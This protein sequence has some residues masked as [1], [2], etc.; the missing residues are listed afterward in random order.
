MSV[1]PGLATILFVG[2]SLIGPHLPGVTELALDAAGHPVRAEAQ[3]INGAPLIWNWDHSAEAQGVDGR[4][5]L[6]QGGIEALVLTE[7]IP[8][9][10]QIIWN[11]TDGLIARWGAA[12][13]AASPEARIYLLE[14][15]HDLDAGP[16]NPVQEAENPTLNWRERLDAD[17]PLW[18]TAAAQASAALGGDPVRIIPAGQAMAR[19][20]DAIAAG[21]VP[22]LTSISELFDDNIHLGPKGR[23][24]V[25]MVQ[26]AVL[27]GRSP[28][29]LPAKL[30]RSWPSRDAI[31]RDDTALAMQR[32]AWETVS[33]YTQ[34]PPAA[35][36]L[37]PPA[38]PTDEATATPDLPSPPPAAVLPEGLT[39]ITNANL[40]LNLAPVVDWSVQQPFLDVV[41]TGRTW[42]GHTPDQWGAW[43]HPELAE[44]GWLDDEGWPKAMPPGL[45]GLSLLILTDLPAGS[46]GVAGRYL[47]RYQGQGEIVIKGSGKLVSSE[48]GRI[49]FDFVPG[50]GLVDIQLVKID[51]ADPIRRISVVRTDR[52]EMLDRGE[53]FNPDFLARLRGVKILRFMGWM[54]TND[55]TVATVADLPRVSDYTWTRAGVPMP[56]MIALANELQADAW[57]CVP[58]LADD[59]LVRALATAARDGLDPGRRAWVELS[60]EVW[61]WLFSQARWADTQALARWGQEHKWVQFYALRATEVADIWAEVFGDKAKDRL[62]RV[63]SSHTGWVGLETDV[64]EAPLVMAEGRDAPARHF[65]AYGITGY[66]GGG[67]AGPENMANLRGWIAE[68]EQAARDAALAQGLTGAALETEVAAHR[69]DRA[70]DTAALDLREGEVSGNHESSLSMTLDTWAAHH[71]EVAR[72]HGLQLVMYEGGS[73]VVATGEDAADPVIADFLIT[74]SYSPQMGDLYR[75]L[76]EGWARLSDAPFMAFDDISAPNRYGSWGALRHLADDNP[77][78]DALANGCPAC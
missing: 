10:S 46:G 47:L 63:I 22:G 77:R 25:A 32:I 37:H 51:P 34:P 5:R 4:A 14:T 56:V 26:V 65:D 78:W 6:A 29:G 45:T 27:T 54:M 16:A 40:G 38:A 57:F 42:E 73:H 52:A 20:S 12:A 72:R 58:H 68:S 28:E 31:I 41:K 36:P 76:L 3:I 48:P 67:L 53:V 59:N 74:L 13:R 9:A 64:L 39:P 24:F 2:H 35:A 44:G 8:L 30:T 62:V 71:A 43:G 1:L 17:L 50:Q 33:G 49:L 61:N 18:E 21:D 60:N 7:A 15:W 70:L 19:M 11:D 55:S 75:S 66:F 69:F 23:Y